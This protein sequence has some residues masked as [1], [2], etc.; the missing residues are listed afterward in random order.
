MT[1][2]T[3]DPCIAQ[4]VACPSAPYTQGDAPVLVLP[5][6]GSSA[7]MLLLVRARGGCFPH[8]IPDPAWLLPHGGGRTVVG[9]MPCPP[10]PARCF[11]GQR[12]LLL[13]RLV[14]SSLA[15]VRLGDGWLLGLGSA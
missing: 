1:R 2:R 10:D 12:G 13:R 5:S 4:G 11:R 14:S 8:S 7:R 9:C 3:R 15:F 6:L